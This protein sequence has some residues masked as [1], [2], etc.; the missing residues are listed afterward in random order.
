M[1]P[2]LAKP[3]IFASIASSLCPH[4]AALLEQASKAAKESSQACRIWSS[5][6]SMS[7]QVEKLLHTLR[8]DNVN[9]NASDSTLGLLL[10]KRGLLL[11]GL[12]KIEKI[13]EDWWWKRGLPEEEWDTFSLQDVTSKRFVAGAG[14]LYGPW[15]KDEVGKLRVG[16]RARTGPK[17]FRKLLDQRHEPEVCDGANASLLATLE[18]ILR[19]AGCKA[20]F[21]VMHEILCRKKYPL[22]QFMVDDGEGGGDDDDDDH[23]WMYASYMVMAE[24]EV[25]F[26]IRYAFHM[27]HERP[28]RDLEDMNVGE[29]KSLA[30]VEGVKKRSVGWEICCP[31]QARKQDLIKAIIAHRTG[32]SASAAKKRKRAHDSHSP[33]PQKTCKQA[34]VCSDESRQCFLMDVNFRTLSGHIVRASDLSIGDKIFDHQDSG[35]TVTWCQKHPKKKRLLVDLYTKES[36]L[37][38]TGSHR[39][40]VPD[41][42][43]VQAKE[44]SI[45]QEVLVASS[46]GRK[47]LQKVTKRYSC[48]PVMELEFDGDAIV[49]ACMPAILSKGT[50]PR[51]PSH[52]SPKTE[53]KEEVD[54]GSAACRGHEFRQVST[55]SWPDTDD[56]F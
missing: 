13:G 1:D 49:A 8:Q 53:C 2:M 46:F 54:G 6:G 47:Q 26:F 51:E 21:T 23:D 24:L 28:D 41:G 10:R 33:G 37:T 29:L 35:V 5:Q 14:D 3:S 30:R 36:M 50:D 34:Q 43:V 7:S 38:V 39:L 18:A 42:Q 12:V 15:V 40:V 17:G 44:L 11:T 27:L 9:E 20:V 25:L 45:D 4:R 32:E 55:Q 56:G 22:Q 31:P 16:L 19:T 52:K 48:I